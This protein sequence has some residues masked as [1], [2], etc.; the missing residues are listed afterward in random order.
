MRATFEA[1]MN[2]STNPARFTDVGQLRTETKLSDV[3]LVFVNDTLVFSQTAEE[4]KQCLRIVSKLLCQEKLQ[5]KASK[6]V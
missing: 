3:V 4:H 2:R 6:C 5:A 1:V